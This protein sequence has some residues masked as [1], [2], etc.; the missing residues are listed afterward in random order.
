MPSS[1]MLRG[2]LLARNN[3]PPKH[4]FLREP[5]G[6]TSQKTTFFRLCLDWECYFSYLPSESGKASLMALQSSLMLEQDRMEDVRK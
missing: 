6:V 2:V 4:R 5:H 1:A 3:V